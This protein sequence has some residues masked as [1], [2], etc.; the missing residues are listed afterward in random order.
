[1]IRVLSLAVISLVVGSSAVSAGDDFAGKWVAADDKSGGFTHV[2]INKKDKT[3]TVQ[4]WGA[5]G[6]GEIDQ[7]KV[8]LFLLGDSAGDTEMKY[9]IASWDHK[10]KETHLTLRL[11][12]GKLVAETYDVFKDNSGRSNYRS[13]GTLKKSQ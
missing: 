13:K 6:G 10:F 9:G 2:E 11:E 7:G 1:M 5:G 3:W 8:T 12:K 4:A